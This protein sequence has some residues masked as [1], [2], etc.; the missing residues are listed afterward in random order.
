MQMNIELE[1]GCCAAN[2]FEAVG[3]F[4]RQDKGGACIESVDVFTDGDGDGV[5]VVISWDMLP[6]PWQ[7]QCFRQAWN[8]RTS[9]DNAIIMHDSPDTT[10]DIPASRQHEMN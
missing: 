6:K 7:I 10:V 4:I 9:Y 2:V 1:C 3:E 8:E 5:G